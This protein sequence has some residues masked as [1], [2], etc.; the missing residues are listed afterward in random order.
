MKPEGVERHGQ[1]RD[2]HLL[3]GG[4]QHVHLAR[5]GRGRDLLGEASASPSVVLPIAETT[6]T[7]WC[8]VRARH[9]ATR[10]ATFVIFSASATDEPPYFWTISA[11]ANASYHDAP[12]RQVEAT[13]ISAADDGSFLR[14]HM[15][16]KSSAPSPATV[17]HTGSSSRCPW[18][19]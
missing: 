19:A 10:R 17:V 1:E 4:Q 13:G 18:A 5:L 2:G 12:R 15:T 6:T 14:V 8:A 7:T 3:A 16:P 9:S 11:M